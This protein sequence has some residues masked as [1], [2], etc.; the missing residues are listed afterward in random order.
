MTTKQLRKAETGSLGLKKAAK[1]GGASDIRGGY[2]ESVVTLL[3][4]GFRSLKTT[5]RIGAHNLI[6]GAFFVPAMPCYGSRAWETERSAGFR[7]SRSANPRTA[8]THNRFAAVRGSS[9][10]THG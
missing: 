3:T 1:Q 9:D 6:V 4:N 8:A 7:V 2:S 5:R 10:N